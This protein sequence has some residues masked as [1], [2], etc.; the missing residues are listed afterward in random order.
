MTNDVDTADTAAPDGS[1][2]GPIP[3]EPPLELRH[4]SDDWTLEEHLPGG[5]GRVL[6][7]HEMRMDAMRAAKDRMDDDGHPCLLVWGAPRSM[8]DVYWNPLFERLFVKYDPMMSAWA[9]VP[10]DGYFLF[11]ACEDKTLARERAREVQLDYD[12]KHLVVFTAD[13]K[14]QQRADH[15][16]VNSL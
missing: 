16:F 6:S 12:F 15:H 1:D 10:E 4:E 3:I 7:R 8:S 9:V 2:D 14:K 5:D 11:D 13:G